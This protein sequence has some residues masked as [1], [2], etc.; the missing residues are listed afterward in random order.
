MEY[1]FSKYIEELKTFYTKMKEINVRIGTFSHSYNGVNSEVIFDTRNNWKLVFMKKGYG[2]VLEIPVEIG[3]VFSIQ[4]NDAYKKFINYFRVSGK[5][6]AFK[7]GEFIGHFKKCVPDRYVLDDSKRGTILTYDKIDRKSDGKYPIKVINWEVV[8]AQNPELDEE[9]YHRSPENLE[10]TR[11]LY[12][13]L[14]LAT[15]D[16]DIT[17]VY[18]VQPEER[19]NALQKGII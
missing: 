17:I 11:E 2:E 18:G 10:K 19:T 1:S 12:P 13:D 3:Y 8:H 15:R 14:Y 5:K 4:G 9:K 16:M 6:G 7:M